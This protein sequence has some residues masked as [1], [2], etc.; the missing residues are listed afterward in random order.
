M[1]TTAEIYGYGILAN[2]ICCVCSICGAAVLPCAKRFSNAYHVFLSVFMG[3]A[4]G[5]LFTGAVVHLIPEALGVHGH[6]D[7]E[8]EHEDNSTEHGHDDHEAGIH[9][10]NY[11]WYTMVVLLGTYAFYLLEM[12]MTFLKKRK[13]LISEIPTTTEPG[14]A[15]LGNLDSDSKRSK[16]LYSVNSNGKVDLGSEDLEKENGIAPLAYMIIIG[17]AIHN[18]TDGLVLG[19]AFSSD[20]ADGIGLTIAIFC[21]ELP[22]ELGDFAVLITSGLSFWQAILA[23]LF[24][25]LTAFI[26]FFIGVQVASY[27]TAVNWIYAVTAGNFLYISLVDMLPE[28]M[29][30][31]TK[32]WKTFCYHNIGIITGAFILVV[33]AVFEE[34]IEV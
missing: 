28:L 19:A 3:L 13:G 15:T 31:G 12:I 10:E 5:T 21:H 29:K 8:H 14:A 32:S 30:L 22:Q 2:A 9:V 7:H 18:T 25:S 17:D 16:D 1:P 26:G 4:V 34:H 24:S 23:N 27:A 33:V 6:S 20:I 11:I